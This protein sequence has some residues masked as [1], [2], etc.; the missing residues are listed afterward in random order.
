VPYRQIA[1]AIGRQP[2]VPAA[3]LKPEEAEAHFE[4]LAT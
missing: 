1:E 4:P 2:G 3:S